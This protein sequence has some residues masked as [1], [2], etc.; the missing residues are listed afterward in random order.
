MIE[1]SDVWGT[2]YRHPAQLYE[3]ILDIATL[4]VLLILYR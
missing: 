3:A 2:V 4:P 1:V